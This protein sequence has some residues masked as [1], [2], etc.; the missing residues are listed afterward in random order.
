[1]AERAFN[2]L[3]LGFQ[4][5]F[6][7]PVPATAIVPVEPGIIAE[8]DRGAVSARE[9]VGRLGIHN[10]GR[11][12]TGTRAAQVPLNGEVT[13]EDFVRALSL[14][15][16]TATI[17]SVNTPAETTTKE[18]AFLWDETSDT[19][20]LGTI[21]LGTEASQDQWELADAKVDQ[22]D[23]GFDDLTVPGASPWTFRATAF[24]RDRGLAALTGA[25]AVPATLET[26][27]GHLTTLYEGPTTTAFAALAELA[28]TLVMF[29]ATSVRNL[30]RR[31][32]GGTT[33]TFDAYGFGE[34][35]VS[36]VA[37]VR[38]TADTKANI[39][40]VWNVGGAVA[41]ERR[42]RI[43]A[44]GASVA[45]SSPVTPKS[46]TCDARVR[47]ETVAPADRDGEDVYEINGY[48]VYDATNGSR[49]KTALVNNVAALV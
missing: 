18:W 16:G 5:A 42:W 12:Y 39:Y 19:S 48:M 14:H 35:A 8:L 31:K 3:Q 44:L 1:M 26:V 30:A 22:I 9:D 28:N 38:I 27:Q 43:K 6:G 10:P 7:T 41:T 46:L 13:Y 21:E 49:F 15:A 11:G 4:S 2:V 23:F 36:F 37:R 45:G 34:A 32:Y 17:T 33:D 47:F 20:K 29:R 40:D 25:L 24:G